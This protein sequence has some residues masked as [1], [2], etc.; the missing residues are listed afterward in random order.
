M[1][2]QANGQVERVNRILTFMIAKDSPSSD[3]SK[4]L[5]KVEYAL[6]NT[7]NRSTG[8][9]PSILLF[10]INQKGLV[11]DKVKKYLENINFINREL[12]AL[13]E[14]A[15][16]NIEKLQKYNKNH[17]DSL[18]K[19]P[20]IYKK[21]DFV[22]IKNVVTTPG[23]NKKLI[24]KYRGPYE[25]T[26]VLLNDRYLIQDIEGMKLSRCPYKGVCS[27]IYMRPRPYIL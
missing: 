6:N 2:P 8:F 22:M 14:K 1:T 11:C 24:A 16:E 10:G 23:I 5:F 17:F 20:K 13:R 18:H 15:A 19:A 4:H 25:V 7:E 12:I 26:K 27:P 9:T 21:G 3:W